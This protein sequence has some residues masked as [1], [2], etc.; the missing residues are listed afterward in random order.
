MEPHKALATTPPIKTSYN[1][2]NNGDVS[3]LPTPFDKCVR[4]YRIARAESSLRFVGLISVLEEL[5]QSIAVGSLSQ[6]VYDHRFLPILEYL[7]NVN[8]GE[9]DNFRISGKFLQRIARSDRFVEQKLKGIPL[10]GE[11]E[12]LWDVSD[13]LTDVGK[14]CFPLW[15]REDHQY[16]CDGKNPLR[17][18]PELGAR[19]LVRAGFP[20]EHRADYGM[21]TEV[22]AFDSSLVVA[23]ARR[24]QERYDGHGYPEEV[25]GRAIR[26][27]IRLIKLV[28]SVTAMAMRKEMSPEEIFAELQRCRGTQFDPEIVDAVSKQMLEEVFESSNIL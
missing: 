7:D 17:D 1:R 23:A 22:P 11:Q 3:T 12:R 25:E 24:H 8:P 18:H 28:D 20:E 5:G 14:E 21:A 19:I 6:E 2:E 10:T 9:R 13:T 4:P 26:L 27:P 16:Y 15:L